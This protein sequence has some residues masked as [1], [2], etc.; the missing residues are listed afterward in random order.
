MKPPE[1]LQLIP[2]SF[3]EEFL[4]GSW[5]EILLFFMFIESFF[6]DYYKTG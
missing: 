3:L 1:T 2:W 6:V 4:N 5:R